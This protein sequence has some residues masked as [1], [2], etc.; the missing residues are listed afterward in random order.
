VEA[1]SPTLDKKRPQEMSGT[2]KVFFN[3]LRG[4]TAKVGAAK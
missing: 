2:S 3:L 1:D 4:I